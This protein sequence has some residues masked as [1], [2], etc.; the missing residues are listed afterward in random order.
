MQ[1]EGWQPNP[2]ST[3]FLSGGAVMHEGK[4]CMLISN[5]TTGDRRENAIQVQHRSTGTQHR[6]TGTQHRSTGTQHWYTALVQML[7][8]ECAGS[9]VQ[10]W[11]ALLDPTGQSVIPRA[12][13]VVRVNRCGSKRCTRLTVCEQVLWC[14]G[15]TLSYCATALNGWCLLQRQSSSAGIRSE[16]LDAGEATSSRSGAPVQP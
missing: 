3:R 15:E 4:I 10:R 6:S 2:R 8:G 1:W 7:S 11:S 13:A 12:L 14:S 5:A 9:L 16:S